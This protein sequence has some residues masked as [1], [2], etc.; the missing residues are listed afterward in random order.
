MAKFILSHNGTD[1]EVDAPDEQTALDAFASEMGLT[2]EA[3]APPQQQAMDATGYVSQGM[4]GLNEGIGDL[5]GMP[6]DL[7]TMLI[8]TGMA[9]SNAMFGTDLQPIER[10]P[11]GS[12][13]INDFM[14]W[15]GA[16]KPETEDEGGQITRRIAREYGTAVIPAL[17]AA[18]TTK[19]VGD[20]AKMLTTE[21]WLTGMSGAGAAL[22]EQV[23]PDNPWAEFGAQVLGATTA[24]GVQRGAKKLITPFPTSPERLAAADVLKKEGID[25]TAGQVTGSK[26]LRYAEGELGGGTASNMMEKQAEQFTSAALKR[27]GISASRATPEVLESA[28][29]TMGKQFNDLS[30]RNAIVPDQQLAADL[31]STFDEYNS[32]AGSDAKPIVKNSIRDIVEGIKANGGVFPGE[33]YKSLRSRIGRAQRGTADPELKSALGGIM[34]SLDDAMGR[35]ISVNNPNDLGAWEQ[36]RQD[37]RNFLVIERAAAGAGENAAMG[38]I[39]PAAL[40]NA[41]TALQGKRGYTQGHGDFSDLSRAGVATMSPLPDSGTASRVAARSIMG[42]PA[43]VGGVMGNG[44]LPGF[45]ALA[46]AAAG[47]AVPAVTGRAMLSG[48]GKGYL[49]NQI[50]KALKPRPG[51]GV[52]VGASIAST[53]ISEDRKRIAKALNRALAFQ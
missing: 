47:A 6:V 25:L 17:G 43:V 31:R 51:Q 37:Y 11:F 29:D 23:A 49:S 30:S 12:E 35:W 32:L 22:A 1:Y 15:T 48:P 38:L 26:G 14:G 44:F 8:N 9:G 46:G 19:T 53:G 16:I 34:E 39:S 33:S 5:L 24:A 42:I 40:K 52:G 41:E 36:V 10:P 13:Q 18:R 50:M 28:Y 7:S 2:G 3:P 4:S 27:A 21:A 45:G 20:A